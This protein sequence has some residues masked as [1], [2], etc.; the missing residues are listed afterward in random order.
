MA[1]RVTGQV[2]GGATQTHDNVHT[3]AQLLRAMGEDAAGGFT[4]AVNGESGVLDQPLSDYDF[5]TFS[6]AVKNG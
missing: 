2:L 6:K 1:I 5:V 3:P 4:A